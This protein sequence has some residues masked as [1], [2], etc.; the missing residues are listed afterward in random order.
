MQTKNKI[1]E[2]QPVN[3]KL[4]L[5]SLWTSFMFLY[6]YVDYFALYMPGKIKGIMIGKIFMFNITP[7]FLLIAFISVSI[8]AIMILLSVLLNAKANRLLNIII[9]FI[10]IP[11]TLFNL[12][13]EAW[14]HMVLGAL[15][16]VTILFMIIRNA[17]MWK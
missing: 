5:A 1:I 8:P 7:D 17:W 15:I 6:I 16:E 4:K 9:A 12:A 14:L 2:D 13:G 11:Y 10:Y 3:I